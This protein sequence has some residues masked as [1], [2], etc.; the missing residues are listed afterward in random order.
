M[1]HWELSS[2]RI[3]AHNIGGAIPGSELSPL[4]EAERFLLEKARNRV[5]HLVMEFIRKNAG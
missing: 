1:N 3:V 4:P 5:V 2:A